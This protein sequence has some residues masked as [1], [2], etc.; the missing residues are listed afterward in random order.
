MIRYLY[1]MGQVRGIFGGSRGWTVVWAVILGGRLLRRLNTKKPK[2]VFTETLRPG[3]ALVIR[4]GDR[5][6]T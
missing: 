5:V 4:E 1:R 3:Q 6:P 2:V